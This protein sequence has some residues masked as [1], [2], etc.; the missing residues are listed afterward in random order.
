MLKSVLISI[1][2]WTIFLLLVVTIRFVGIEFFLDTELGFPLHLIYTNSIP[3]GII[4]GVFWSILEF[5]DKKLPKRRNRTF[6][7][8]VVRKSLSYF[9]IMILVTLLT[10]WL[11]TG[12][13][14]FAL[15][16]A[17]SPISVGNVIA[18]YVGAFI[19][20][21]FQQMNRKFGPGILWKYLTG[22]YFRPRNE[23]RVF[24]FLDL[25][26]STN[27]AEKLGHESYSKLIQDCFNELTDPVLDYNGEIYQ[28]VGDEVVITWKAESGINN[29]NCIHLFFKYVSALKSRSEYFK[30]NYGLVPKFKAG[31]S[32]GYVTG[33]E[34]GELKSEIAF[35][36]DALNTASRIQ[37]L[38][39]Q[40]DEELLSSSML[41]DR[42]NKNGVLQYLSHGKFDL[43][44]KQEE[45]EV[46]G[47][48]EV[49]Q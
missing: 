24:M 43:R 42:L 13:I 35:H 46:I 9:L 30:S 8:L 3:G 1:T 23:E 34:L 17:M 26:S 10:S 21:F 25:K 22:K 33:V 29:D 28:Y 48:R 2:Y 31:M 12:S 47:I 15:D 4:M 14:E 6:G 37:G 40:L 20:V 7:T 38:C 45:V 44:G 32:I 39:N 11:G 27:I 36:G 41:V 18:A 19:F 16:Y 49:P 5:I